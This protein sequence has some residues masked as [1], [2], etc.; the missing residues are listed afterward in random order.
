MGGLPTGGQKATSKNYEYIVEKELHYIL[1]TYFQKADLIRQE[2]AQKKLEIGPEEPLTH[3]DQ[4]K[5]VAIQKYLLPLVKVR[6]R[7]DL[8]CKFD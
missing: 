8:G 4:Q 3:K 1:E 2:L 7:N 5:E 6:I